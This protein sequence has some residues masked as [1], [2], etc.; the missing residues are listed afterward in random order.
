MKLTINKNT[1]IAVN[2]GDFLIVY[3][4]GGR[5]EIRQIVE[6]GMYKGLDP[7]DGTFGYSAYT[8]DELV[9]TYKENYDVVIPVKNSDVEI[10]IGGR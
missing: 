1:D 3:D 4:E 10:T 9:R 7:M 2:V 8:V 5:Q 6:S